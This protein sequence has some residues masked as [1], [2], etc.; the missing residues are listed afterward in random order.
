MG[1]KSLCP[2]GSLAGKTNEKWKVYL[3]GQ[4]VAAIS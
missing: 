1:H 2:D 3:C 4:M